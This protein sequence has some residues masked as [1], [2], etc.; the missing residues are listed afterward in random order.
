MKKQKYVYHGSGKEFIG[1]KLIP[2]KANDLG[3]KPDNI[4]KAIYATNLRKCAIVMGILSCD[5]IRYSSLGFRDGKM[6]AIIYEG[7]PLYNYFYLYTL[8]SNSFENKPKGSHQYLSLISVR[9]EKIEKLMMKDY[10]NLVRQASIKE[11]KEFFDRYKPKIPA[12]N[13]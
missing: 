6:N 8:P 7:E 4:L 2:K 10:I 1:E 11:K 3:N 13:Y 5:G 9:P 12:K